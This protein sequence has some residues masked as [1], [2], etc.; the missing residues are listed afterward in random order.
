MHLSFHELNL[1]VSALIVCAMELQSFAWASLA[2]VNF[3]MGQHYS[4]CKNTL[5]SPCANPSQGPTSIQ[6]GNWSVTSH[7]CCIAHIRVCA[8]LP[9]L[10]RHGPM[11][12]VAKSRHKHNVKPTPYHVRAHDKRVGTPGSPQTGLD[13]NFESSPIHPRLLSIPQLG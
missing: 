10:P 7:S 1:R 11:A 9:S 3:S 12:T 6:S 2:L 4:T 13:A 5:L 8:H